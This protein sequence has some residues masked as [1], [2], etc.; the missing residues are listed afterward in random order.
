ML[1]LILFICVVFVHVFIGKI[2]LK[3]FSFLY[4]LAILGSCV[5]A[6]QLDRQ[7]FLSV[8]E[9]MLAQGSP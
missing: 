3:T 6:I 1:N 9:T 7:I 8:I 4:H 2:I 5:I